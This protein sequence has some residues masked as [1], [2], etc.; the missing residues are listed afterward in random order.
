MRRITLLTEIALLLVLWATACGAPSQPSLDGTS[1][2][3]AELYGQSPLA[4]TQITLRFEGDAL[5]G[6][7]GCN[8][9][10]GS[11][12]LGSN[13]A[14]SAPELYM[15]EMW[16]ADPEGLMEQETTYLQ[17]LDQAARIAQDGDRLTIKDG[18]GD[19]ILVFR[20]LSDQ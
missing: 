3:L 2:E 16:C 5:S 6:N 8:Q 12:T 7:A 18:S 20:R 13:G 14:F 15:T 4:G 19:A 9:Y 1:W 11:F 17:A 10:G